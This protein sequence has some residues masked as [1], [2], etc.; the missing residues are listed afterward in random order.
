MSTQN[1]VYTLPRPKPTKPVTNESHTVRN[2]KRN[3]GKARG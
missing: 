2:A 3:Q 1:K